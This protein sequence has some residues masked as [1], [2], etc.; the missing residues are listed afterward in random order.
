MAADEIPPPK[1]Q[2]L[3][4]IDHGGRE[5]KIVPERPTPRVE[6]LLRRD[7]SLTIPCA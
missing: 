1:P 3:W 4:G 6:R 5:F 2:G 7:K